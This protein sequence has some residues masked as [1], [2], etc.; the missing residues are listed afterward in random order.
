M[1]RFEAWIWDQ[2]LL[3]QAR[4][5]DERVDARARVRSRSRRSLTGRRWTARRLLAIAA[6]AVSCSGGGLALASALEDQRISPDQWVEGKRVRPEPATAPELAAH[7]GILRR[8]RTAVDALPP[9]NA[10]AATHSPMA[11]NGVNPLL[12]RRAMGFTEGGAWLIPGNGT[13]CLETANAAGIRQ[14]LQTMPAG[15][16]ASRESAHIRGAV[17]NT[18]CATN[19]DANRGFSAGT[20]GSAQDPGVVATAGIVPDGVESV[21]VTLSRGDEVKLP[22]HE[23]VYMGEVRGWPA[24]VSFLG[25]HGRVTLS[26]GPVAPGPIRAA[27]ARRH[28]AAARRDLYTPL[29][30]ALKMRGHAIVSARLRFRAPLALTPGQEVYEIDE[31]CGVDVTSRTITGAV[32]RGS[33]VTQ[34]VHPWG[35]AAGRCA[36]I[37]SVKVFYRSDALP[38]G[39]AGSPSE[40]TVLVG[41]LTKHKPLGFRVAYP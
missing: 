24:S 31:Y 27:R 29:H 37:Y 34:S 11:A 25:P 19:A 9:W 13:I 32:A 7:L 40:S 16:S 1:T 26:N 6:I 23:N 28:G 35:C 41:S 8:A 18:A 14:A 5:E 15:A 39:R 4:I 21:T 12:S 2:L 30:L 33:T 38:G 20:A 10:Y 22:V 36:T 3:E 17:G